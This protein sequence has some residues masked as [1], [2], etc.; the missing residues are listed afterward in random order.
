MRAR[1][2]FVEK[3]PRFRV[4]AQ[5]LLADFNENLSLGLESLRLVNVYDLFG[6]S[7]ELLEQC[8]YRVFG[9]RV[10]DIVSD[11][12]PL[13][14]L[15][16][17]AVEYL[18]GQFDQR[19]SSA[20]DCVH[21]LAPEAK[22]AIRSARLLIF[23]E[24]TSEEALARVR[25][26]F[27]NPVESREKDMS[28]LAE[29][30]EAAVRPLED[31]RGFTQLEGEALER[32]RL[33]HGL[34]MS[35]ADIEEVSRYFRGEGRDT[36]EPEL[37]ILATYWSDHCRHTTFNTEIRSVRIGDYFLKPEL[38]A[39]LGRFESIR[40]ELGRSGKP[41]CLMELAAIGAR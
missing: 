38:E 8:R 30:G 18:P 33:A 39:L 3:A 13:D 27:I 24:G 40:A 14:G 36:G 7:D 6:F 29:A 15:K 35:R 22:I 31:L 17:L 32:F 10:T 1:R 19:A 21:L 5:S 34:A 41:F 16:W 2:I 20:E 28:R 4:E 26:Y 9:E 37:R 11:S 25:H 23:P 12:L